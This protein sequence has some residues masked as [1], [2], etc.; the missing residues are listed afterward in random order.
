MVVTWTTFNRT[1]SLVEYSPWGDILF[2]KSAKGSVTPFVDS[3]NEKR[4]MFIHRVTLS[5]L[6][7]GSHYGGC[8]DNNT[9]FQ[10]R[11]LKVWFTFCLGAAGWFTRKDLFT[12]EGG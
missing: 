9:G 10:S 1:D 11:L 6:K 4:K 7:P 3:G 5:D 8:W 2:H 12:Q